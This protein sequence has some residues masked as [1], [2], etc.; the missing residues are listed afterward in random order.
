[1]AV[2]CSTRI[3]KKKKG[4]SAFPLPGSPSSCFF[5]LKNL[6]LLLFS[7]HNFFPCPAE[8]I[9]LSLYLH[10]FFLGLFY[11]VLWT[12]SSSP[13]WL[14]FFITRSY[15]S[16]PDCARLSEAASLLNWT[17]GSS[18]RTSETRSTVCSWKWRRS[19]GSGEE[20]AALVAR[21]VVGSTDARQ[22][23]GRGESPA[24]AISILSLPSPFSRTRIQK[25]SHTPAF[26]KS[27]QHLLLSKKQEIR[28]QDPR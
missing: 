26:P 19:P 6:F 5:W 3:K 8:F 2:N 21:V 7:P 10:A 27:C 4:K 22:P 18:S 14:L 25:A 9:F 16:H 23:G 24:P 15:G 11:F 13:S 20:S 28:T 12:W 17:T 1:M